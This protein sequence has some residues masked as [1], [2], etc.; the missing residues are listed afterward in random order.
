VLISWN[1][2]NEAL[3]IPASLEEA[4]ERLTLTGCEVESIERPCALLKDVQV[5]VIE[6]LEPHPEK[7][8]LFVAR[9]RDGRGVATAVTA[10]TNLSAGDKVPYGRPGS[11]MADGTALEARAFGQVT[12]EGMLLSADELGVPEA[13]D[14]FGILRLPADAPV[15]ADIARYLGLDDAILDLSITPDRGDLLSLLGVARELYGLFPEAEWKNNPAGQTP[16]EGA[17]EWPIDF[18]GIYL[19]DERCGKYCL[20]MATGLKAGPSPLKT[21]IAL[22]LLG[23]RPI[24]NM[25]DASNIAMLVMGQPT[26]AFDAMRLPAPEITVRGAAAGESIKTLDGKHHDLEE[27]DL[28]ITS[29]GEP[30]GIAGVMG[31]EGSE[32]LPLTETVLLEAA[33]FD[34]ISVSRTSRRLGIPSEAAFRFAR[35]VD[36]A[37][38]E[39]TLA[40]IANLLKEWGCAETAYVIKGASSG[41]AEERRVSLTK[42]NLKKILLTDDLD[43][44]DEILARFGLTRTASEEDSRT[45]SVPSWRP[46]INMEEDLIEEVGRVLGY[47]ETLPPSLPEVLYGRGDIGEITRLKGDVRKTLLSRGYVE[48]VNYSFLSPSFI[49]LLRL[50]ESDRRANP[51]ELANPLSIEQSKMRTTLLPGLLRSLELA[52]Q[53]GWRAPLRAFELGRVFLPLDGGGWEEVERIAGLAYGGRDH[54]HPFGPGEADDLFSLK[55]DILALAQSRRADLHFERGE[56]PFGHK[57]QTARI[58]WKEGGAGY[59]LRLKPSIEKE[60]ECSPVFAFELDLKPLEGERLPAFK[61]VPPFPPVYRDVSLVAPADR[62]MDEIVG[63]IRKEGGDLLRDARLFDIYSGKGIPEG[64]RSLAFTLAYRRDDRTLTD[65]EVDEVHA[66]VRQKLQAGGYTLR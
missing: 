22:T 34:A 58:T 64:H 17:A 55:G 43:R 62:P 46:D 42:K 19:P 60:L 29:G 47:N 32:I 31:G 65:G 1:M 51:L 23:M 16:A 12:S 41:A 40:Y 3:S 38:A 35:T 6:A 18:K 45:Y 33:S 20:G 50:P 13:A 52:V 37:L 4:A 53:S 30:V 36:P 7:E 63:E 15:G 44:A 24:S 8:S 66:R 48:L 57:G 61:E 25:V 14:E 21:R 9:V 49:R 5:A 27:S 10:A 39:T 2:L 26:H 59:L 28:L 56:E 54:R 11:V